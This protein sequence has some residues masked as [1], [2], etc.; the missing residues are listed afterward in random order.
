MTSAMH[1]VAE[2]ETP[3][4]QCTRVADS[5]ALPRPSILGQYYDK[6][7]WGN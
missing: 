2:R 3:T 4:R 7:G 6:D 1:M 5:S